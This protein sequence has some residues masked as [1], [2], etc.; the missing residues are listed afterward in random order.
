MI[1]WRE[2]TNKHDKYAT[3]SKQATETQAKIDEANAERSQWVGAHEVHMVQERQR[4]E[5]VLAVIQEELLA[6]RTR[7]LEL[8]AARRADADAT[9]EGAAGGALRERSAAAFSERSEVSDRVFRILEEY[10]FITPAES[11]AYL[12]HTMRHARARAARR[13]HTDPLADAMSSLGDGSLASS[14][15]GSGPESLIP[16]SEQRKIDAEKKKAAMKESMR[17]GTGLRDKTWD[18]SRPRSRGSRWK[19]SSWGLRWPVV[20]RCVARCVARVA[21]ERRR[22]SNV[23]H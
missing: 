20:A 17:S 21:A 1:P 6:E 9:R 22:T 13:R 14:V 15:S 19:V 16:P 2:V 11:A 12:S 10:H 23:E 8:R 3:S 4:L 7:D 18:V 5:H